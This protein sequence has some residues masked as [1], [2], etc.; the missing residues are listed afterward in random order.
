MAHGGDPHWMEHMHEKKGALRKETHT[1]KDKDISEKRLHAAAHSKNKT[2][3][4]RAR[5]AETFAKDRPK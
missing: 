2:E 4:A 5:L 3:A 1:G